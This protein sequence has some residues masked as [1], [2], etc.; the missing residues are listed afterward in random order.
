MRVMLLLRRALLATLAVAL[1]APGG[2]ANAID[3]KAL[4]TPAGIRAW[5]VEDR[6]AP[7]IS[8]SYSFEGGS[9]QDPAGK[10]GR[11]Q[12]A[13]ALLDQGAGPY[14][15]T[16]FTRRQED[17]AARL[18]F[19]VSLDRF[20]GSVRMLRIYRGESIEL[21][22]LALTEPRFD[23]DSLERL[24]RQFVSGLKRSE[25]SPTSVAGRTLM[26][27]TFAPHPYGRPVDGTIAGIEAITAG[28]L[29][30]QVQRQFARDRL[31]IA[32]VGDVTAD[33][34]IAMI[35][36]AFGGLPATTGTAEAPPWSPDPGRPGGRT[37]V[38]ERDVPQSTV[39]ITMPGIKRDD[40]DWYAAMLMNHVLGGGGFAGRLMNEVREKRGLA[41][42]AYSHL[43]TYRRAG[44]LTASVGTANERVAQSI[45][46]IR[47]QFELMAKHGVTD[48]ELSDAKAYLNGSIA[49]S[50]DSTGSI[51]GLLHSMQVDGLPP[52][53]MARRKGLID[54]VTRD[55][56]KRVADR[57]L[58]IDPSVTVVVGRPQGITSTE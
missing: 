48:T 36:R 9:A 51:A 8:I 26:R 17:V 10:E 41:Y 18:G 53:H 45:E 37:I 5:L 47:E 52:D 56:V 29:R 57:I 54:R 16:A 28:D 23:A 31:L 55:D 22:R 15:A 21:L 30:A 39:M 40:P 12:L 42:G 4:V 43:S 7:V 50:L 1:V 44:L 25:Q 13:A 14:D 46:I 6:T 58:R 20:S 2:P 33:E 11:A 24:Q 27:A 34:A 32:I 49:L 38:I 35:D 19:G 3:I